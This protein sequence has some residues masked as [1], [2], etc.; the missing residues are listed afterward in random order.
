MAQQF[1]P[2]LSERS[3]RTVAEDLRLADAGRERVTYAKCRLAD[4]LEQI[5][6]ESTRAYR[7]L[8]SGTLREREAAETLSEIEALSENLAAG[9]EMLEQG[10]RDR[11]VHR[12]DAVDRGL[13]RANT[14]SPPA[15]PEPMEP[16]ERGGDT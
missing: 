10:A 1:D 14:E 16:E 7:Q 4:Q 9:G 6:R 3:H 8:Q 13:E 12:N 2:P 11:D 15:S 5:I